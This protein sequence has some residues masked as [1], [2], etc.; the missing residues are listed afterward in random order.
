MANY[1]ISLEQFLDSLD[2][3]I[4]KDSREIGNYVKKMF[5]D[6]IIFEKLGKYRRY[7]DF[8]DKVE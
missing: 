3:L 4:D 1:Y 6:H 8:K 5:P 7:K 2:T